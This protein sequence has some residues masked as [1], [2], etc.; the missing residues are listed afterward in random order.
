MKSNKHTP[1]AGSILRNGNEQFRE[2]R[3]RSDDVEQL[4]AESVKLEAKWVPLMKKLLRA[5]LKALRA[6]RNLI[7]S[8]PADD[9]LKE[10]LHE[11]VEDAFEPPKAPK[12][13]TSGK[14]GTAKK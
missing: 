6:S 5:G 9:E 3:R 8:F 12:A 14:G 11:L 4:F 10:Y 1:A 7:T 13:P 2:L